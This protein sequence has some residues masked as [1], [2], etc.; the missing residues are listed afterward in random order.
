MK[1]KMEKLSQVKAQL[2]KEFI[3]IDEVIDKVI[4]SITSW[5]LI[6][7][8]NDKPVVV[9]LWG[10]TGTG[11]TSLVN[12]LIELLEINKYLYLDLGKSNVQVQS[13]YN[14]NTIDSALSEL[15]E[16]EKDVRSYI[17]VLDE[18]QHAKTLD[19]RRNE[20]DKPQSRSVWELLDSG[21]VSA[22]SFNRLFSRN[23]YEA[24][25]EIIIFKHEGVKIINGIVPNEYLNKIDEI[26]GSLRKF[27]TSYSEDCKDYTIV[28][29]DLRCGL[30][31]VNENLY[32]E[33][34]EFLYKCSD[35]DDLL[36][37]LRRIKDIIDKPKIMDC[38]KSLVFVLGNLDE[39]YPMHSDFNP[40]IDADEYYNMT[41]K[42]NIND[43]K[44]CLRSRFRSEQI[45]RLGNN[46]I[47]Y[48]SL[49]KE[50]FQKII[51]LTL[52]DIKYKYEK[53][54][55]LL[56]NFD[57]SIE[58]LLYSESVY[59]VQ[60]VRP[61]F[62]TVN[63]IISSKLPETIIKS[64]IEY[65][66]CIYIN[67][68][69]GDDLYNDDILIEFEY[70]DEDNNLLGVSTLVQELELGRL[71]KNKNKDSQVITGVHESGHSIVYT[72]RTN[73]SPKSIVSVSSVGGGF[74]TKDLEYEEFEN[75]E[76]LKTEVMVGLAGRC[77]EEIV[78]GK[79]NISFGASNDFQKITDSVS[80]AFYKY[81][82]YKN[83]L[84]WNKGFQEGYPYG[85][86]DEITENKITKEIMKFISECETDTIRILSNE[87]TLLK[88]MG[89][90]LSNHRSMDNKTY[91]KYI[92]TFSYSM[93]VCTI[94]KEETKSK[95]KD[96]LEKF[97]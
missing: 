26:T 95:Y 13:L 17:F 82:L 36:N 65:K 79:D 18:F 24:L 33:F 1:T 21:K 19:E 74:I 54:T 63:N 69:C 66:D 72:S 9:N 12:R 10:L 60:G 76:S 7:E 34:T 56:I 47:L 15:S 77:A 3:G 94:D 53:K 58:K 5:Y 14:S 48:P 59:P 27:I 29:L 83:L 90:Y 62:T 37:E 97:S 45:S 85:I 71:R 28:N 2:K 41:K 43:I 51:K 96:L 11:K 46:H 6:P 88:S 84:F 87:R 23:Y 78:F 91:L 55:N 40:D 68:K 44:R 38:S 49:K 80:R 75:I 81:G 20:I 92:D 4:E 32:I 30:R 39:A 61:I 73:K 50:S 31:Y 93:S 42:I 16:F 35:I 89:L 8:M 67:C 52:D 57:E 25:S 22:T 64:E 86:L 70:F